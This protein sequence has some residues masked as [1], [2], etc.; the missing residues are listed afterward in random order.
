MGD[1]YYIL[2]NG[3]LKR[4]ENT[5]Y[6]IGKDIKKALPIAQIKTI[7]LIG[8]VTISSSAVKFLASNK[9]QVHIFNK[10]GYYVGS[11][12]PR[13]RYISGKLLIKQVEHCIDPKKR[14]II[15]KAFVRGAAENILQNCKK[16]GFD[17]ET[18]LISNITEEIDKTNKITELMNVEARIRSAYYSGFTKILPPSFA[19]E[20]RTR[21]PPKNQLNALISFGNS[22]MYTT[23]LSQIY[24]TQL[25]P[26]ISYLHDPGERRFSLS[27]DIAEIFKP[28]I[29][30]RLIVMLIKK[31][32]IQ[33]KHFDKTVNACL[34]TDNGR[35]TFLKY[36][37]E[38]LKTTIKHRKLNR[39]VS[40]QRL[41]RL[42]LYKLVK[43]I[44]GLNEY[45]PFVIW[46]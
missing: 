35:R 9:I 41:I 12:Y 29:V 33:E 7:F 30:D 27:L 24:L 44:L 43:H 34:L 26:T 32:I 1:N 5:I 31:R 23:V 15:A 40:Y 13:E 45:K 37:D 2:R 39:K 11:F 46:W 8:N 36:Y 14:L 10:Y 42:E 3:I 28:L 6:F 4:K 20:K 38:R 16:F 19:F 17:S 18:D 25:N 21:Q 22:L